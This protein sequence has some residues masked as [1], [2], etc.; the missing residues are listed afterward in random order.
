MK[1][2]AVVYRVKE[3]LD[4]ALSSDLVVRDNMQVFPNQILV[5]VDNSAETEQFI[6]TINKAKRERLSK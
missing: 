5:E 6:I 2:D 1:V 3:A 4:Q